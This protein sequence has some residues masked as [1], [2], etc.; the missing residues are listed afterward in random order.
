MKK[1]LFLFF[2]LLFI[3]TANLYSQSG[4]FWQNPKPQGNAIFG[5]KMF[6]AESGIFI[7]SDNLLSTRDG[8]QSWDITYTG[9][10]WFNKSFSAPAENVYYML[11]DTAAIIRSTDKGR[12]WSFISNDPEIANS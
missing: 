1:N 10:P 9:F 6:D 11:A 5:I 4:W 2:A 3:F 8:G 12:S 7:N